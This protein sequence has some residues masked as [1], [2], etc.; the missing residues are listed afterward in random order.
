M[1]ERKKKSLTAVATIELVSE[2][3]N[4]QVYQYYPLGKYVVAAPGVCGGRPTLKGRRLDARHVM[5]YL[6]TGDTPEQLAQDFKLPLEA[7][8]EV[9]ELAKVYDYEKSHKDQEKEVPNFVPEGRRENSPAIHRWEDEIRCSS[10]G[11][12]TER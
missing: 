10:P 5:G 4:G 11:G 8:Q 1:T 3:L 12:T 9:V 6:R 2:D 7:I